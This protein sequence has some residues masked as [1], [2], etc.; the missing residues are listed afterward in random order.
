[1]RSPCKI[2]LTSR[3]LGTGTSRWAHHPGSDPGSEN[4]LALSKYLYQSLCKRLVSEAYGV[5]S[6]RP[7][8]LVLCNF[9]L[10][11]YKGL[12]QIKRVTMATCPSRR[13]WLRLLEAL[14]QESAPL[15]STRALPP[16][17]SCTATDRHLCL[18]FDLHGQVAA[19]ELMLQIVDEH[20]FVVMQVRVAIASPS[21]LQQVVRIVG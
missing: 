12:G 20:E 10:T 3:N 11:L 19:K 21:S 6:Y 13:R 7:H 9:G 8:N 4:R 14:V 15:Q 16:W 17:I 2:V 18:S 1:M 5:H